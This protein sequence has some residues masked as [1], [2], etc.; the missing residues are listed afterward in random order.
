MKKNL[1]YLTLIL[2]IVFI[3]GCTMQTPFQEGSELISITGCDGYIKLNYSPVAINE[4]LG[5][6]KPMGAISG[7]GHVTPTDHMYFLTPDWMSEGEIIND[8]FSP[9][10][11]TI[12][13]IEYMPSMLG[14]IT[15][16][17]YDYRIIIK[18]TCSI[19]SI[20]IHIDE[21][22]EKL[23]QYAPS[24]LGGVNVNIPVDGGEFIGQWWGQL[25]YSLIDYNKT[26]S[27][28]LNPSRFITQ[29]WRI[30]CMDPFD[31]FEEPFRSQL[32]ELNIRNEVP[33]GGKIDYDIEGKL[34]GV[35][36]KE[37][38]DPNDWEMLE[39][40][41]I[42]IVYDYLDPDYIII[43]VGEFEGEHRLY[44]TVNN[45]FDPAKISVETGLVKYD[46][47]NYWYFDKD[48]EWWGEEVVAKNLI[49]K[50]ISEIQGVFLVQMLD[51]ETII[52]EGFLGKTSEQVLNFTENARIYKR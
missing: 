30:H 46:L 43:S 13:Y 36:F 20:F 31:Y 37:D 14:T 41:A 4:N 39:Y 3:S 9:A 10:N 47:V 11:G 28:I 8:I 49:G 26:L 27:G 17:E 44:G 22:S 33:F 25:D 12:T 42:S 38:M 2:S 50:P 29:P 52:T 5:T 32:L 19:T 40:N 35:W 51:N 18:H 6:V 21:L 1:I 23:A 24:E 16:W 34:I 48:G 15:E 45:S 7:G